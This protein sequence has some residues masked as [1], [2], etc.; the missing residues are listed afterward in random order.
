MSTS[1]CLTMEHDGD[2]YL[3][4]MGGNVMSGHINNNNNKPY[5]LLNNNTYETYQELSVN[6]NNTSNHQDL[7]TSKPYQVLNI[8]SAGSNK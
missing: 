6:N 3:T 5:T 4:C 7:R 8:L 1:T 2:N